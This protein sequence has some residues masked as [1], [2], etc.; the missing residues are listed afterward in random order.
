MGAHVKGSWGI[1]S[2]VSHI[3]SKHT[4]SVAFVFIVAEQSRARFQL[5]PYKHQRNFSG[6]LL[7]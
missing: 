5:N 6:K 4:P 1:E 7:S 3:L 2:Q